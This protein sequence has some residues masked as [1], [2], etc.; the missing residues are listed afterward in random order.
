MLCSLLFMQ[1]TI[2]GDM[3]GKQMKVSMDYN[4]IAQM[5]GK[6][7]I[8]FTDFSIS[9]LEQID[10]EENG[11]TTA[12][13]FKKIYLIKQNDNKEIKVAVVHGQIP[14]QPKDFEVEGKK[15]TL[16][17]Y[18]TPDKENILGKGIYIQLHLE[19]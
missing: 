18:Q 12:S 3:K 15:F 10:S 19:Q 7:E 9:F 2:A 5:N 16:F 6:E 14:P 8:Q 1:F 4:S 17:T 11:K 13:S